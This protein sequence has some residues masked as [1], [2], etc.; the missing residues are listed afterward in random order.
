MKPIKEFDFVYTNQ[1]G[2]FNTVGIVVVINNDGKLELTITSESLLA[3][4]ELEKIAKDAA[5]TRLRMNLTD[6][7]KINF[8]QKV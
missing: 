6:D 8:I 1:N 5:Q 7:Y 4:E 3:A 2:D